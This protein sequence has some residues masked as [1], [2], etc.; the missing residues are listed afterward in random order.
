[1]STSPPTGQRTADP[2]NTQFYGL[3]KNRRRM[4]SPLSTLPGKAFA[5][6]PPA[7]TS[8]PTVGVCARDHFQG[9]T[10]NEG[11]RKGVFPL[12]HIHWVEHRG[13][14]WLDTPAPV[15]FGS[16]GWGAAEGRTLQTGGGGGAGRWRYTEGRT[17][18][19]AGVSVRRFG[20]EI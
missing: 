20:A 18:A 3:N 15:C 14:T 9:R 17:R 10:E 2:A 13:S 7:E 8:L 11:Q 5:Q 19:V 16:W 1:M 6:H 12:P 4:L